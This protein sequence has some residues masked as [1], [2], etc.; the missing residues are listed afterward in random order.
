MGAM[1]YGEFSLHQFFPDGS[2][3]CVLAFVDAQTAVEK[4]ASLTLRPAAQ[5]GIVERI[6]I[7]DGGDFIN[8]E[9]K[10]GQGITYPPP[11]ETGFINDQ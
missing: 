1:N 10:F 8:F 11:D 9:W 7:T 3:E 2:S 6:I 4:A 5:I